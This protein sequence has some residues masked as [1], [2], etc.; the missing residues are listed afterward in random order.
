MGSSKA[1]NDALGWVN[2]LENSSQIKGRSPKGEGWRTFQELKSDLNIGKEK[3]RNFLKEVEQEGRLD[4]FTGSAYSE[5]AGVCCRQ[6]WYRLI[7]KP[8]GKK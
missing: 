8:R 3:L 5:V 4:T 7:K 1:D 2:A 6:V